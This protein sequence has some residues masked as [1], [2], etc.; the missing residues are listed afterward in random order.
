[1]KFKYHRQFQKQLLKLPQK[2]QT[3][4]RQRLRLFGAD[5]QNVL[6]KNHALKGKY[7]GCRSISI[8]GDLRVIYIEHSSALIEFLYIGTHSQLYK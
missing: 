8:G 2:Q 6:L 7:M 4:T 5:Q 1:M 3:I